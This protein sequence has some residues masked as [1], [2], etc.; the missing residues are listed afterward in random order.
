ME[1]NG[2]LRSMEITF[3]T[4]LPYFKNP[5]GS[6]TVFL[7]YFELGVV[8]C[9][10]CLMYYPY[11]HRMKM[12]SDTVHLLLSVFEY[13]LKIST[14]Y[15][16]ICCSSFIPMFKFYSGVIFLLSEELTS[17][18]SSFGTDLAVNS[19]GFPSSENILTPASFLK[20]TF[21]EY[22]ILD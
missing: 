20:D 15:Y 12:P 17:F 10:F 5:S 6:F 14:E 22:T 8:W 2:I 11:I 1:R 19:L 9:I 21:T 13:I 16:Y 18:S 3:F 4:E 7:P